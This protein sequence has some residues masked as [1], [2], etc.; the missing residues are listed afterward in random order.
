ML[1]SDIVGNLRIIKCVVMSMKLNHP[2][3]LV[4]REVIHPSVSD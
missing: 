4:N 2:E 3:G 1:S